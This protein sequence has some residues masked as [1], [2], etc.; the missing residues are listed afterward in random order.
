MMWN[1]VAAL[2]GGLLGSLHCL[3]MCGPFV[4][5]IAAA[6]GSHR[7]NLIRQACFAVGRITSYAFM[8]AWLAWGVWKASQPEW[9]KPLPSVLSVVAG[10]A[11]IVLAVQPKRGFGVPKGSTAT[12]CSWLPRLRGVLQQRGWTAPLAAGVLTAWIP[13]GLLY[14]FLA[15]AAASSRPAQGAAVMAAFGLGTALPLLSAGLSSRFLP[16]CLWFQNGWIA[17]SAIVLAGAVCL[18][19]GIHALGN[20]SSACPACSA[21]AA[22]QPDIQGPRANPVEMPKYSLPYCLPS[23][24]ESPQ[25]IPLTTWRRGII[26]STI[27]HDLCTKMQLDYRDTG[28]AIP[29]VPVIVNEHGIAPNPEEAC[30]RGDVWEFHATG[31]VFDGLCKV[32]SSPETAKDDDVHEKE[33]AVGCDRTMR[34]VVGEHCRARCVTRSPTAACG[35]IVQ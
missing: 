8:G 22:V 17:R 4:L 23:Y 5:L 2:A 21:H 18:W 9:L 7:D 6:S 30:G 19:R 1:Y 33:H 28:P 34:R 24:F 12:V 35:V 32:P 14:A 29:L 10:V 15:L 16:R 11:L 25:G 26:M 13:C 27:R 20:N 31:M 3:G